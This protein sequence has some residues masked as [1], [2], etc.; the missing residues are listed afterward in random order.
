MLPVPVSLFAMEHDHGAMQM[1]LGMKHG[2]MMTMGKLAH[3]EVVNGVKATF[4]VIDIKAK[5]ERLGQRRLITSWSC[6]PIPSAARCSAP[7]R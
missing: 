3:E 6:L 5:M 4:N 2:G 1:Q 7:A